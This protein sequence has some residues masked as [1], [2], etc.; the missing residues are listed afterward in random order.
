M[1]SSSGLVTVILFLLDK[2]NASKNLDSFSCYVNKTFN[3]NFSPAL[4]A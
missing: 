2:Q 1:S 3:Y 4:Y